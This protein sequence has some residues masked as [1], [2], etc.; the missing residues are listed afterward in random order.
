MWLLVVWL[1][2]NRKENKVATMIISNDYYIKCVIPDSQWSQAIINTPRPKAGIVKT[3]CFDVGE[4]SLVN[5]SA[6]WFCSLQEMSLL[7]VF[8]TFCLCS[9]NINFI[10]QIINN[11]NSPIISIIEMQNATWVI[12]N[13]EGEKKVIR[14][15]L[16]LPNSLKST[17]K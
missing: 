3:S 15:T 12:L 16:L 13:E 11:S 17:I 9:L 8:Q 4:S 6:I 2:I 5:M 14:E 1:L 10:K 7:T